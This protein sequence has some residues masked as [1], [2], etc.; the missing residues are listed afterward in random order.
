MRRSLNDSFGDLMGKPLT[1]ITADMVKKR[2]AEHGKRSESRANLGCRYLRAVF[3]FAM[4]EYTADDGRPIVEHNPV[5]RLSQTRAWFK[6]DRREN[7]LTE[8]QISP[9]WNAVGQADEAVRDYY[10]FTLLTGLRA[11]EGAAL[12]WENVERLREPMQR[13]TD[14]V[15][16]AAGVKSAEVIAFPVREQAN[17]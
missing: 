13:I 6:I 14:F 1:K 4:G 2:H 17:V 5:R 12:C 10:Q 15:L 16:K 7:F 9:W 11:S 8:T 3:N